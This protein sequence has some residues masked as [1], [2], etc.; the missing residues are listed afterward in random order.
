MPAITAS[1]SPPRLVGIG[2]PHGHPFGAPGDADGQ[3]AV[4]QAVL[5]AFSGMRTPG[6]RVDLDLV[7]SGPRLRTHPPVPPPIARLLLRKPW[8]LP[9]LISG[10]IPSGA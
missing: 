9:R 2:Y 6:E 7:Y 8:L 10:N 3:R 4:L 1:V 5:E